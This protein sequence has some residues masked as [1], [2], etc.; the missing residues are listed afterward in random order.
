[1]LAYC[2]RALR[3]EAF[4]SALV[5]SGLDSKIKN[6]D[7]L[8]MY[9]RGISLFCTATFAPLSARALSPA[10]TCNIV[11]LVAGQLAESGLFVLNGDVAASGGLVLFS[12]C[13]TH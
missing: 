1:M 10:R 13:E 3:V 2:C 7:S 11:S 8:L 6:T 5:M 4:G 12:N 9:H